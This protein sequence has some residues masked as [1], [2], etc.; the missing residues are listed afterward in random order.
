[1]PILPKAWQQ[2]VVATTEAII[3]QY[4]KGYAGALYS[5]EAREKF[6]DSCTFKSGEDVCRTYGFEETAKGKLVLPYVHVEKA[7]PGCLPGGGQLEGDCVS[8]GQR[9]A[10]LITMVCDAISGVPDEVTG[11]IEGLPEVSATARKFGVLSTEAIYY[12][13]STKPGHGWFC[14]EAAQVSRTKAGLILR[15]DYGSLNLER[16]TEET[17]NWDQDV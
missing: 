3:A 10:N 13:R 1:M 15:K 16:Y 8:W 6:L 4:R 17:C 14:H 5:A 12:F 2:P 7:Y 11:K 9:C